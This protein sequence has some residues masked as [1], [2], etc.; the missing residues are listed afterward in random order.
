MAK[1]KKVNRYILGDVQYRELEIKTHRVIVDNDDN[2]DFEKINNLTWTPVKKGKNYYFVNNY[3]TRKYLHQ[4]I[5]GKE[6]GSVIDH[7][8]QNTLDNRK[9][10]LRHVDKRMNA[11]NISVPNSN[12]TS[13]YTGVSWDKV[14]KKWVARRR[15]NGKYKFLGYFSEKMD[16]VKVI[17]DGDMKILG[18]LR[19]II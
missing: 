18:K 12:N 3:K 4:V 9:E 14:K 6:E 15:I 1:K 16:A 10:N 7:I 8:N 2:D 13:G 17:D 11:L 19:R 5:L